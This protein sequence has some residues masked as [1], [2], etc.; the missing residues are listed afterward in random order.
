[1]EHKDSASL[2]IPAKPIQAEIESLGLE[3]R[4]NNLNIN[5][6]NKS[7]FILFIRN[8]LYYN[9]KYRLSNILYKV[10]RFT[11]I[12]KFHS[13]LNNINLFVPKRLFKPNP[14]L[15][16]TYRMMR[17]NNNFK[18]TSSLAITI[19]SEANGTLPSYKGGTAATQRVLE[20]NSTT[21]PAA[22]LIDLE[23]D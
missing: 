17:I 18:K 16:Y 10:E 13:L 1:V 11:P 14:F 3:D 15:R 22:A 12:F 20:F 21:S 9:L 4:D 5:V 19:P 6:G 8:K 2:T 23:A 7:E